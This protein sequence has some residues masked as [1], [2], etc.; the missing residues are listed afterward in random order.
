MLTVGVVKSGRLLFRAVLVAVKALVVVFPTRS[1]RLPLDATRP[2]DSEDLN[3]RP[4]LCVIM[5]LSLW[6]ETPPWGR[7]AEGSRGSRWDK[8]RIASGVVPDR[9]PTSQYPY[10]RRGVRCLCVLR[11]DTRTL[12]TAQSISPTGVAPQRWGWRLIG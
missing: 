8:F 7:R 12:G 3:A 1:Q 4:T 11:Q 2:T 10:R 9:Q 5:L 6:I